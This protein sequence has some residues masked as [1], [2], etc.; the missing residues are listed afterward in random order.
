MPAMR[1]YIYCEEDGG[2]PLIEWLREIKPDKAVAK[3][4]DVIEL[5]KQEG[6][7]LRRPYADSLRDGIHELRGKF[8]S[9]Q[10]RI[11]YFFHESTAV[12]SHGFIKK[13]AK[14]P[15]REIDLALARKENYLRN[16]DRHAYEGSLL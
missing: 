16:P 6:N 14:I 13:K 4:L 8:R 9:V 3:C 10:Y 11:L 15:D 5:L 12:L 1:V 7:S 2:V